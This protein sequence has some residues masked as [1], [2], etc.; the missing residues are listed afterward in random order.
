MKSFLVVLLLASLYAPTAM[1]QCATGVNTGGQCIPPEEL[2]NSSSDSRAQPAERLA[3]WTNRWG[4]IV[5][6][7]NTGLDGLVTDYSSKS[8][9][10]KAAMNA[11]VSLGGRQCKVEQVYSNGCAAVAWGSNSHGTTSADTEA[12]AQALAMQ[13]CTE[14]GTQGCK[15]AYSACS[16]PV[17]IR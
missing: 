17:R 15:I 1:S 7:S 3:R 13:A 9:A 10:V 11:C 6:D 16:L 12:Q 5:I 2:N 4:A 8:A 14:G